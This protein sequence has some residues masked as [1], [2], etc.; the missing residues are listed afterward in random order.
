MI[1]TVILIVSQI[2]DFILVFRLGIVSGER[3]LPNSSADPLPL[4]LPKHPRRS[5][6][7]HRP[8][9]LLF[10]A[11]E[12]RQEREAIDETGNPSLFK[13]FSLYE[14]L[15][16]VEYLYCCTE[17]GFGPPTG[18]PF[19]SVVRL[20]IHKSLRSGS[21]HS[22][23]Q[24]DLGGF[25][26]PD[27]R[28]EDS[29]GLTEIGWNSHSE[30]SK[31]T[32]SSPLPRHTVDWQDIY[33]HLINDAKNPASIARNNMDIVL[34]RVSDQLLQH[35][36]PG[37]S[38]VSE[39]LSSRLHITD[40]D[41][42]SEQF[43]N[44]VSPFHSQQ[45]HDIQLEQLTTFPCDEP[46]HALSSI[47]DA[48]VAIHLTPLSLQIPDRVR[49]HKERLAR[50][51]TADLLLARTAIYPVPANPTDTINLDVVSTRMISQPT[52][53]SSSIPSIISRPTSSPPTST[54]KAGTPIEEDPVFTRLRTH[55][56]ILPTASVSTTSPSLNPTLSSVLRHLPV[57]PHVNPAT[58]DYRATER[59][60]A[61][62][63]EEEMAIA[64]GKEDPRARKRAEKAR[65]AR[66]KRE[67]ARRRTAEEI[68]SSQRGP[69]KI[70]S[71]R[72]E[73]MATGIGNG[74][75]T[76]PAQDGREV[77]SSQVRGRPAW[78]IHPGSSPVHGY[79]HQGQEMTISA[80]QPEKG[81]FGTRP[82]TVGAG[83]GK[84]KAK[85]KGK[86]RAAGF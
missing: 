77:Q 59:E 72:F 53:H 51:V 14:D 19:S 54:T 71:S 68:A 82:G 83:F 13:F 61:A 55:T 32:N 78:D 49:V 64:A 9:S 46:Q 50:K 23:D 60:L 73:G 22:H 37:I 10:R 8:V 16:I 48:L 86:K 2:V 7:R 56:N 36:S 25:I 76:G 24:G 11:I 62:E 81:I 12:S 38:L 28:A 39:V 79:G 85:D 35:R 43:D 18:D 67:E 33:L 75:E 1:A 42:D 30:I 70:V 26:V 40:V 66:V 6:P 3:V 57:S 41:D 84:N 27:D 29:R 34:R 63:V 15:S 58:Y 31:T 47:Y 4:F 65:L 80:T 44:L 5:L 21:S 52:V 74:I 69:P 20:P 17:A 45:G